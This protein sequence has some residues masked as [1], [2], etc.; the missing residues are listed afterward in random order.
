MT[1]KYWLD[2]WKHDEIG[3]HQ[4]NFNP[5]LLKYWPTMQLASSSQIFVPLCGKTHDMIWLR[6]QGHSVLGVELSAHAVA[7]FYKENNLTPSHTLGEK[8]FQFA[9][10]DIHILHGDFFDLDKKDLTNVCAVYDRASMVALPPETRIRY[11]QH[12]LKI[13]PPATKILLISF[14]YPPSEMRGPPYAVSPDE[15]TSLYQPHAKV[16]LLMENDV[17][18]N[19]P[20]FQQRGLSQLQES[21]FLITRNNTK[22]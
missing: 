9:V 6:N 12:M 8:F 16:Q 15:V 19:N 21:I 7:A 18:K 14:D 2:R 5:Y 20:R 1:K 10:G 11:V 17:L 13:L 3:F 4:D 22:K